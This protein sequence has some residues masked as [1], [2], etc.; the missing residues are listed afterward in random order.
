VSWLRIHLGLGDPYHNPKNDLEGTKRRLT[1]GIKMLKSHS[2]GP[3]YMGKSEDTYIYA[4]VQQPS[5]KKFRKLGTK[6]IDDVTLW[7]DSRE[8]GGV[9]LS[10]TLENVRPKMVTESQ[11]TIKDDTLDDLAKSILA[12]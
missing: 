12:Y 1:T 2:D 4:E 11:I 5:I 8:I 3:Y 6:Q 7:V 10:A 9:S